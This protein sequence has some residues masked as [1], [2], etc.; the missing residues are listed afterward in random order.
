MLSYRDPHF[1][2][3]LDVFEE[4]K[5]WLQ[6]GRFNE[7]D[8]KEAIL[9]T[10]S[11]L[12]TPLSPASKAV[13]EYRLGKRGRTKEVRQA[14]RDGVLTTTR[15]EVMAAATKLFTG[16]ASMAAVTSAEI[17]SREGAETTIEQK[18]I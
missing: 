4:A 6:E 8:L 10:A 18:E 16:P 12:D 3:T 2:R 17:F 14:F 7:E 1:K 11:A 5:N 15:E 9:Q 13:Q